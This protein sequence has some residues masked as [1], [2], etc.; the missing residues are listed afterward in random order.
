VGVVG[1]A[2]VRAVVMEE[3]KAAAMVVER[4][5][6]RVAGKVVGR[7]EVKVEERVAAMGVDTAVVMAVVTAVEMAVVTVVV[8]A[9]AMEAGARAV[10]ATA[11]VDPFCGVGTVLAVANALGLDALGVEKNRKRAEQ[12]RELVVRVTEI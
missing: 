10:G 9:A 2:E 4:V 12:A 7:A 3:A 5:V 11:V 8:M 1:R 6:E